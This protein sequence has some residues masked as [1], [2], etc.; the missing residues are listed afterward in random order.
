MNNYLRP[1]F[2]RYRNVTHYLDAT[3]CCTLRVKF[4]LIFS[5]Y[6]IFIIRRKACPSL[7]N[8]TQSSMLY[9]RNNLYTRKSTTEITY[10]LKVASPR[11]IVVS[12]EGLAY[13]TT[14]HLISGFDFPL[15]GLL[16]NTY[17][18]IDSQ[19]LSLYSFTTFKIMTK[20][21][22]NLPL[23]FLNQQISKDY[24]LIP[25]PVDYLLLHSI[26]TS[27]CKVNLRYFVTKASSMNLTDCR[28]YVFSSNNE[29]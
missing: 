17:H 11:E 18:P 2:L 28:T 15:Y 24:L 25:C 23:R 19:C 13:L 22:S 8:L 16:R 20:I 21:H 6:R 3:H 1:A 27:G 12:P 26:A 9:H 14:Q 10:P 5:K 4:H 29:S 7:L